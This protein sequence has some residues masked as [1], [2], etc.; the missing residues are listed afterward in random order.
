MTRVDRPVL[1]NQVSPPDFA[2]SQHLAHTFVGA[3]VVAVPVLPG[4]DGD[5]AGDVLLGPG[6]AELGRASCRERVC[7]SV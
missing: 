7:E 1:P 5:G 2:L 3:D 6:A 4:D